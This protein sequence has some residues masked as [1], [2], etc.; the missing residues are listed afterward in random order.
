M[1]SH[2]A[3]LAGRVDWMPRITV[4]VAA[5][6]G[7]AMIVAARDRRTKW[8][9]G[10]GLVAVAAILAF[11]PAALVFLPPAAINVAF[12]AYFASTL[13]AGREPRIA[14]FARIE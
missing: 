5:I 10:A 13:R 8:L 11:A 6:V 3:A 1:L 2:A 7:L 4:A 9:W 14:R 12:G